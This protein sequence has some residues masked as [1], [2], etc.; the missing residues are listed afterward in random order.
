MLRT[1]LLTLDKKVLYCPESLLA[2]LLH[3]ESFT[4]TVDA[5]CSLLGLSSTALNITFP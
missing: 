4:K 5:Q 2:F 1:N 3:E